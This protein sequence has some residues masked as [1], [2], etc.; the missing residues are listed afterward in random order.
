[1]SKSGDFCGDNRQMDRRTHG[2]T[3]RQTNYF[4][5]AHAR[6]V[7]SQTS[8]AINGTYP[9]CTLHQHYRVTWTYDVDDLYLHMSRKDMHNA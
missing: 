1:M 5:P 3:D 9:A 4:T 6:G 8:E 7:I 2:Q